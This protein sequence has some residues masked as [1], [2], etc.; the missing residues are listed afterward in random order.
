[1]SVQ[2]TDSSV[3]QNNQSQRLLPVDTVFTVFEG[4]EKPLF[5]RKLQVFCLCDDQH[6]WAGQDGAEV[7]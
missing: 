7:I 2:Q 3:S 5:Y 4:D 6:V 1:M